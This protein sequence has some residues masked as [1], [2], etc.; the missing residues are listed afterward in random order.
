MTEGDDFIQVNGGRCGKSLLVRLEDARYQRTIDCESCRGRANFATGA[1]TR[2]LSMMLKFVSPPGQVQR[3]GLGRERR[4]PTRARVPTTRFTWP[5][6]EDHCPL[7]VNVALV[8]RAPRHP[9]SL[10]VTPDRSARPG[11]SRSST[12][13]P[14]GRR[15]STCPGDNANLSAAAPAFARARELR[16]VMR[17]A[18]EARLFTCSLSEEI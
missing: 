7:V 6:T 12:T 2:A 8:N 16:L 14:A 18:R 13:D 4:P 15:R 17:A 10:R 9:A 3:N 1:S 11:V 5:T